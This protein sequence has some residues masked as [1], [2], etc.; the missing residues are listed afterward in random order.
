MLFRPILSYHN[1]IS[2]DTTTRV[3][4][5]PWHFMFHIVSRLSCSRPLIPACLRPGSDQRQYVWLRGIR[6]TR[7]AWTW[8]AAAGAA[9]RLQNCYD[10]IV[11]ASVVNVASVVSVVSGILHHS[12]AG[13]GTCRLHSGPLQDVQVGWRKYKKTPRCSTQRR[14]NW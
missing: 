7:G 1:N 12:P 9:S 8:C 14:L 10:L 2:K 11:C 13:A 4:C 5:T 6:G 3:R